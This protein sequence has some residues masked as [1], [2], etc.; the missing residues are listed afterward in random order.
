MPC[1]FGGAFLPCFI[2]DGSPV[3]VKAGGQD[4]GDKCA[5]CAPRPLPYKRLDFSGVLVTVMITG[6]LRIGGRRP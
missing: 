5:S 3:S 1:G 2:H 4:S 6:D